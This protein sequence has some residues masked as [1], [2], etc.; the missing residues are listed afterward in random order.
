MKNMLMLLLNIV[1]LNSY[2]QKNTAVFT[3]KIDTNDFKYSIAEIIERQVL[4]TG[5][6][7]DILKQATNLKTKQE[8]NILTINLKDKV[9]YKITF[10]ANN[11]TAFV[12]ITANKKHNYYINLFINNQYI[13]TDWSV[14]K[15]RYIEEWY[16]LPKYYNN[17]NMF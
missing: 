5:Q 1:T 10:K 11:K 7:N 17:N 12:Y 9:K 8:N 4:P 3:F 13:T 14:H 6:L 2:S 15:G 16:P